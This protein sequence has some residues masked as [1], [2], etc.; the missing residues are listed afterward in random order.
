MMRLAGLAFKEKK[1]NININSTHCTPPSWPPILL[2]H[3]LPSLSVSLVN[4]HCRLR[5]ATGHRYKAQSFMPSQQIQPRDL[6]RAFKLPP[7]H[8]WT[9]MT[10]LER[11]GGG[12]CFF[13]SSYV[14]DDN[15]ICNEIPSILIHIWIL[16]FHILHGFFLVFFSPPR[17]FIQHLT[18]KQHETATPSAAHKPPGNSS[19]AL[20]ILWI[21]HEMASLF[22]YGGLFTSY[23][24]QN[25]TEPLCSLR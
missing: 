11:K 24:I 13:F 12:G 10:G 18:L 21:V 20:F 16:W 6:R 1:K 4:P 19:N 23:S 25:D 2:W 9:M 5:G 14:P 17:H 22:M 8:D 15:W 3:F 7:P